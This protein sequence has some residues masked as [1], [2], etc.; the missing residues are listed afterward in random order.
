MNNN[1]ES[2]KVENLLESALDSLDKYSNNPKLD[3]QY[4]EM[5]EPIPFRIKNIIIYNSIVIVGFYYY[6]KHALY[7]RKKYNLHEFSW[8]RLVKKVFFF[9]LLPLVVLTPNL[10]IMYGMNPVKGFKERQELEEKLLHNSEVTDALH[11][12]TK[13]YKKSIDSVFERNINKEKF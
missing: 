7:Y 6:C 3:E 9:T 11:G 13:N 1:D 8:M 5:I 10:F 12:L 4:R 2:L